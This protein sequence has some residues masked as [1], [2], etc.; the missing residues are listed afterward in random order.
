M[1]ESAVVQ[2]RQICCSEN[3]N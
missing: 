2:Q 3:K 1:S